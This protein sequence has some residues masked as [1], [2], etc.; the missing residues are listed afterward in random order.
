MVVVSDMGIRNVP[1]N[2]RPQMQVKNDGKLE[3]VVKSHEISASQC[4]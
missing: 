4:L 3:D 1:N 2:G